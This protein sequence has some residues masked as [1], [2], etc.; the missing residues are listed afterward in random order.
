MRNI[1]PRCIQTCILRAKGEVGCIDNRIQIQARGFFHHGHA[2]LSSRKETHQQYDQ[3][4]CA[5]DR[6]D[7]VPLQRKSNDA[8]DDPA[9]RCCNQQKD[10]ERDKTPAVE[11]TNSGDNCGNISGCCGSGVKVLVVGYGVAKLPEMQ[12]ATSQ[13]DNDRN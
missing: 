7:P 3:N 6:V 12:N 8:K 2:W 11:T 1:S 10:S 4:D 13:S 9:Y 5:Y